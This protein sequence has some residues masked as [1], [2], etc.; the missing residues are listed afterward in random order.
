MRSQK[1]KK[2]SWNL[3]DVKSTDKLFLCPSQK[4]SSKLSK[5]SVKVL[6]KGTTISKRT[7]KSEK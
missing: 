4:S 6:R 1:G 7:L 2:V 3:R 5:D